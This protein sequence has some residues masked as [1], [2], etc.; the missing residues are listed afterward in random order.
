ME[1]GRSWGKRWDGDEGLL[2]WR[3]AERNS[4]EGREGEEGK[5]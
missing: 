4:W 3:E 5:T 2:E 1:A